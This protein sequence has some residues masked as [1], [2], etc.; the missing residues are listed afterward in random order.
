M[1][2]I[3]LPCAQDDRSR[4]LGELLVG[5]PQWCA[6]FFEKF[7]RAYMRDV[8]MLARIERALALLREERRARQREEKRRRQLEAAEIARKEAARP[9]YY[10][11]STGQ[12][13]G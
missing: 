9:R 8:N 11:S 2:S 12:L 5:D 10:S 4:L 7:G 13:L 3:P 6:D 1:S